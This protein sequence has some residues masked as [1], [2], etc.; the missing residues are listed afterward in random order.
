[1]KETGTAAER[2]KASAA[3]V[4]ESPEEIVQA[5]MRGDRDRRTICNGQALLEELD[6]GMIYHQDQVILTRHPIGMLGRP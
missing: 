2:E 6:Q 4:K 1:M 3:D 5:L